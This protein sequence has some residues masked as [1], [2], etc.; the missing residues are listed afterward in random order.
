[1]ET[2]TINIVNH[3]NLVTYFNKKERIYHDDID[4]LRIWKRFLLL[5]DSR[6]QLNKLDTVYMLLWGNETHEDLRVNLRISGQNN[7]FKFIKR[8]YNKTGYLERV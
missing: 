6:N 1:M 8:Q 3:N 2:T 5:N 7:I 4:Q